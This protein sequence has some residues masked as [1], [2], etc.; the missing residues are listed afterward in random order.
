MGSGESWLHVSGPESGQT[1]VL[2]HG[3]IFGRHIWKPLIPAF[4]REFRVVATDLP[5]HGALREQEFST[6]SAVQHL[7]GLLGRV[8]SRSA[9]WVGVSMGG[10]L[11]LALARHHPEQVKGL[12]LSG[13]SVRLRGAVRLWV[14]FVAAPLVA[15]LD[16]GWARRLLASRT[17]R[18]FGPQQQA[19]AEATIQAGFAMRS[20]ATFFRE[21]VDVDLHQGLREF[22]SPV[23]I[24]NGERDG[25]SRRGATELAAE[26]SHAEVELI[27]A[28]GHACSLEQPEAF[29]AAVHRFARRAFESP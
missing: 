12:V 15:R 3:S 20:C 26:F 4:E 5:G 19:V 13:C 25:L 24:L 23:L 17:R 27:Q 10:F 18:L 28:A 7:A 11:V 21:I 16:V 1:L 8:G 9:V 29:A 22:D 14:R 2:V 6:D